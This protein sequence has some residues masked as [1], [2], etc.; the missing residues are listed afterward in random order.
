MKTLG[1]VVVVVTAL[2]LG[3]AAGWTASDR[4]SYDALTPADLGKPTRQYLNA[5]R[6]RAMR[7]G[8]ELQRELLG[9]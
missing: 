4:L 1:I 5:E 6:R 7:T 8:M 9:L 3:F 2:C